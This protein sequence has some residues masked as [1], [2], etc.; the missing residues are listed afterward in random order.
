M[1]L[2]LMKI[3]SSS[4]ILNKVRLILPYVRIVIGDE[5]KAAVEA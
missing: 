4:P 1:G 3:F 5:I 2:N